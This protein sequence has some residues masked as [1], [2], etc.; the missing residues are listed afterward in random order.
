[1]LKTLPFFLGTS[2]D[3][4]GKVIQH[5]IPIFV[6]VGEWPVTRS[7]LNHYHY[8]DKVT[9][10]KPE[11]GRETLCEWGNITCAQWRHVHNDVRIRVLPLRNFTSREWWN[12]N[13][14]K[15][16]PS[17]YSDELFFDGLMLRPA[18][19][20]FHLTSF[21]EHI[22]FILNKSSDEWRNL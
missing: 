5:F 13:M 4:W 2:W 10:G 12:E 18:A 11:S 21:Y 15:T 19:S 14:E 9:R 16:F 6:Q 7:A 17:S 3:K 8:Y 22:A 20:N 1:M